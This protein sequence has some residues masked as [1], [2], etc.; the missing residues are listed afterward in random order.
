[1]KI[2]VISDIHGN[3]FALDK[4]LNDLHGETI[5]HIVCLGDAIQGGPQPAQTVSKLRDLGCPVVM[6]N[7]DS[8]LLKGPGIENEQ[9]ASEV[10]LQLETVR[11]WSLSQLSEADCAFIQSFQPTVEIP[12]NAS[13]S[14][15]CFHGSPTWFEDVIARDTPDEFVL[16]KLEPYLPHLMAGGHTHAPQVRYLGKSDS[17]FFNPGSV[18]VAH[19]YPVAAHKYH[20]SPWAEYAVLTA[21]EG[22]LSLEFRRVVYDPNALIDIYRASGRPYLEEAIEQYSA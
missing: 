18:G 19:T 9:I 14:L 10:L 1:M 13:R 7:S 20:A 16:A 5:D 17:F 4:V 12:L 21:E 6:G 3:A 22:R 11:E 8:W 15:L 2:A